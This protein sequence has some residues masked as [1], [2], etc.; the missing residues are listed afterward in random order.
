MS[1]AMGL[2]A[3]QGS[4]MTEKDLLQC[5]VTVAV[6]DSNS[7]AGAPRLRPEFFLDASGFYVH[8]N[9]ARSSRAHCMCERGASGGLL[10]SLP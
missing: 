5:G 1:V 7:G 4:W 3:T 8:N 2:L 10:D 6:D 9:V